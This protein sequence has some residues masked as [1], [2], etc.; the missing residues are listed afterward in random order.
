MPRK[1]TLSA[2]MNRL[3]WSSMTSHM[4]TRHCR[5]GRAGCQPGHCTNDLLSASSALSI[6]ALQSC[7][8]KLKLCWRLSG[9]PGTVE[10]ALQ[11]GRL[12]AATAAR[13]TLGQSCTGFCHAPTIAAA[14]HLARLTAPLVMLG[15]SS[16]NAAIPG[17]SI[18]GNLPLMKGEAYDWLQQLPSTALPAAESPECLQPL[19]LPSSPVDCAA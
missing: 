19:P 14:M 6:L 1:C 10:V 18:I 5:Q 15:C 2:I 11:D 8:A 12:L 13:E 9:R 4:S 7:S 3:S 17:Y 16:C